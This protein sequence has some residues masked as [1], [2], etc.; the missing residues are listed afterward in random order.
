MLHSTFKERSHLHDSGVGKCPC[1]QTF[2]FTSKRDHDMKMRIH[3][4]F[5]AKP[6]EGSKQKR[7]PKK[8]MTPREQQQLMA[9]RMRMVHKNH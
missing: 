1:S 3:R 7:K 9:E 2:N 4:K 6:P 8:A 5:C